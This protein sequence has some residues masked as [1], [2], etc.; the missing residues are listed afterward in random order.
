MS[1]IELVYKNKIKASERPLATDSEKAY[2]LFA[3]VWN[4]DSIELR[5]E[6]K[7]L[8]LNN[9]RRVLGWLPV[10]TGG[11]SAVSI[12]QR[13]MFAAALRGAATG[14]ILAHNHPSG[15]LTPSTADL[16]FTREIRLS[17]EILKIELLDHLI[18]GPQR[19]Q[20]LSL[21]DEGELV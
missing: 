2:R 12:D 1:E 18:I 16:V 11:I 4:W 6:F 9:G 14:I 17:G 20:Y 3:S 13:L 8:F 19:N 10:A 5:E 7:V 21:A 15:N